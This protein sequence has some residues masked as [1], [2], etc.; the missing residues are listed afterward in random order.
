[1]EG[2]YEEG[3]EVEL[4]AVPAAGWE[5]VNWLVGE[6]EETDNPLEITMDSDKTVTAVFALIPPEEYTLTINTTGEGTVTADPEP[7]EG[8]YQEGTEVE[9]TA[10]PAEGWDFS[11][12]VIDGTDVLSAETT[13]VMSSNKTA[14]AVFVKK[15]EPPFPKVTGL[16]FTTPNFMVLQPC[17]ENLE[18]RF[19]VAVSDP[20]SELV[21]AE[22][23]VSHVASGESFTVEIP[24]DK[25]GFPWTYLVSET[26]LN[27]KFVPLNGGKY[28]ITVTATN[29]EGNATSEAISFYVKQYVS[30]SFDAIDVGI[31]ESA[32]DQIEEAD[33]LCVVTSDG[34]PG[35]VEAT[36]TYDSKIT[37]RVYLIE[38]DA[39]DGIIGMLEDE[40]TE[41]IEEEQFTTDELTTEKVTIG[42]PDLRGYMKPGVEYK[43]LVVL[44]T[45]ECGALGCVDCGIE[46]YKLVDCDFI[47]DLDPELECLPCD[48]ES[49]C[50]DCFDVFNPGIEINNVLST[51]P[52]LFEI[53]LTVGETVFD[54]IGDFEIV[55]KTNSLEVRVIIEEGTVTPTPEGPTEMNWSVVTPTGVELTKVCTPTIDLKKP[56]AE[57]KIVNCCI[58]EGIE[59]T[60]FSVD[61]SDTLGLQRGKIYASGATLELEEGKT[62]GSWFA[63]SGTKATVEGTVTLGG[64][65]YTIFVE[66]EDVFCNLGEAT[67]TCGINTPPKVDFG[68]ICVPFGC[69][70]P[71]W[72]EE[73]EL[74][75]GV[76][77]EEDNFTRVDIEVS[78][79]E[80]DTYVH[81]DA[82]GHVSWVL[83]DIDCET[84][85]ATLVAQDDCDGATSTTTKVWESPYPMDNVDPTVT[86][87]F[88]DCG[89]PDECAT[90][91]VLAWEANDGCLDF[92]ELEVEHGY[93]I[94]PEDGEHTTVWAT[95]TA[96]G[97][98]TWVFEEV[99]CEN[100]VAN[101]YA[102]DN[103]GN[104]GETTLVSENKIDTMSPE[105]F[106]GII[107]V[108]LNPYPPYDLDDIIGDEEEFDVDEFKM[109]PIWFP[110]ESCTDQNCLWII[111]LV[112]ENCLDLDSLEFTTNYPYMPCNTPIMERPVGEYTYDPIHHSLA[113]KE[114]NTKGRDVTIGL[115]QW[116]LPLIDCETFEATLT[117][118]DT[119]DCTE[120]GLFADKIKVD[121]KIPDIDLDWSLSEPTA[122]ATEATVTWS[123]T[124]GS[125]PCEGCDVGD[126]EI[127]FFTLTFDDIEV[128]TLSI[129][130]DPEDPRYE[131]ELTGDIPTA[132]EIEYDGKET[133]SGTLTYSEVLDCVEV[134]LALNAWGCCCNEELPPAVKTKTTTVD[135]LR[136]R[137]EWAFDME[138]VDLGDLEELCDEV[139]NATSTLLTWEATDNCLDEV[140]V[141]V[142]IGEIEH[143]EKVGDVY[144]WASKGDLLVEVP[145]KNDESIKGTDDASTSNWRWNIGNNVECGMQE[146]LFEA[147]DVCEPPTRAGTEIK[148]DTLP[149]E[150]YLEPLD[151]I[152]DVDEVVLEWSIIAEE[153]LTCG[154]ECTAWH[155]G[156]IEVSAGDIEGN[157]KKQISVDCDCVLPLTGT[158]TWTIGDGI[159]CGETLVATF[160]VW[161]TAGNE[162][163][164]VR[165]LTEID[166]KPPEFVSPFSATG[167][168]YEDDLPYVDLT[169][170]A[171]DNCP[172]SVSVWVSQG[173]L[174][175]FVEPE[176]SFEVAQAEDTF[177]PD[178]FSDV[179]VGGASAFSGITL[180]WWL[181][182]EASP[183]AWISVMDECCNEA[184]DTLFAED[185]PPVKVT[186]SASDTNGDEIFDV[187][188]ILVN[189]E[190]TNNPTEVKFGTEVTVVASP[191]EC[192]EFLGWYDDADATLTTD[193]EYTFTAIDETIDLYA[194]YE[195]Y[196]HTLDATVVPV[197]SGGV[198]SVSS[199]EQSISLPA[200]IPC[201]AGVTL[202]A[203]I[204]TNKCWNF[205]GWYLGGE[206]WETEESTNVI[207]K[208]D[209]SLEA[210]FEKI[211]YDVTVSASPSDVAVL[212][213]LISIDN[214]TGGECGATATITAAASTTCWNF[215]GW[216]LDDALFTTDESTS[217]VISADQEYVALYELVGETYTVAYEV[218]A[219][220]A[221][222]FVGLG[223]VELSPNNGF[224]RTDGA[225]ATYYCPWILQIRPR[226][227][228]SDYIFDYWKVEMGT[229]V[230]TTTENPLEVELTDDATITIYR[231]FVNGGL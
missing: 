75:W 62:V 127:G 26:V 204:T 213:E 105:P 99:D 41:L 74:Y 90:N 32:E 151:A 102:F 88:A 58:N 168:L 188:A 210:R 128:G 179:W 30:P 220:H 116:C 52:E 27:S 135:G 50:D 115:M 206:L 63:L 183:T 57:I 54:D 159:D 109:R 24:E 167:I 21:A 94:D 148:I 133:F 111:W 10:V 186:A 79:G 100:I 35:T 82:E 40:N 34:L 96:A 226:E 154:L 42:L 195:Q 163:V 47:E 13:V 180:R 59:E 33:G 162:S 129:I 31:V 106:M 103:C 230:S 145:A 136:P 95:E 14:N 225:T 81:E 16:S 48:C 107:G 212:D 70:P 149:P 104:E 98:I 141:T 146:I 1:M 80:L 101:A 199:G 223:I 158:A 38:K 7:V 85:T 56:E 55:E 125:F 64:G 173:D 76:T 150:I 138:P 87:E 166:S 181:D 23:K 110:D 157:P 19:Q 131:W 164:M 65:E 172:L 155:V 193:M 84:I 144:V 22:Y 147:S 9:L 15:E 192:F 153:C 185:V 43:L 120:E 28:D 20:E 126:C 227:T 17:T 196:V 182:G 71:C 176:A 189:E 140:L 165:K 6:A 68:T 72:V 69:P 53:V 170:E 190:E 122:C 66:V 197:E 29:T 152:C 194:L 156:T 117:A 39:V 142:T 5:F 137:I 229:D 60:T 73:I 160:T 228:D 97:T 119:S 209:L 37:V 218:V 45:P 51:N 222:S 169:W 171:T 208:E 139:Y 174:E 216:Y 203:T 200:E 89:E 4:T 93:L 202:S 161:D 121:N 113:V 92:V 221:E 143:W 12:W 175:K 118:D 91:A 8:K 132:W 124:D 184:T 217:F 130:G 3:T 205:K 83:G 219:P 191:V 214:P 36:F 215:K 108:G 46:A 123:I 11:K 224:E 134:E 112:E 177:A 201:G 86:L 231:K 78:H 25:W 178:Y 198:I 114:I 67:K 44:F 18:I 49:P 77:D 61:F 211:K 2:K 187:V 207:V